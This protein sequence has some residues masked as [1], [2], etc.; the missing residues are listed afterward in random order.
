MF[1]L[2]HPWNCRCQQVRCRQ[3]DE[4]NHDRHSGS[5]A[6]I[7]GNS[8]QMKT[9]EKHMGKLEGKIAVVTGANSGIGLATYFEVLDI[10]TE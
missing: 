9:E 6:A 2:T 3:L 1:G 10:S 7:T 5:E 8:E 4:T